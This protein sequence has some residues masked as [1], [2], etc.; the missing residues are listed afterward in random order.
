MRSKLPASFDA[1]IRDFQP[2]A[3]GF[4]RIFDRLNTVDFHTYPPHNIEKIDE[5]TSI[6]TLALAGYSKDELSAVVQDD[7][8]TVTGEKKEESKNYLYQGIAA[9][10]FTKRFYLNAN[11][12]VKQIEYKDGLLSITIVQEIPEKSKPKALDII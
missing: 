3:L 2:L 7:I 1:F 9:R 10:R 5:T 11:T 8:L 4:D 12:E 6:L